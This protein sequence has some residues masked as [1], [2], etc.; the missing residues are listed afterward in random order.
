MIIKK[1]FKYGLITIILLLFLTNTLSAGNFPRLKVFHEKGHPGDGHYIVTEEGTPFFYL[2]DTA[3]ELFHRLNREEAEL[4]LENRRQKNFTVIQ[5]VVLAEFD[6]LNTPNAYGD[7]PLIDNDPT[8]PNITPGSSPDNAV[9]YD[10]WDHVDWIVAK[11]EEKGLFIGMLPTWGDKVY[12]KW[13]IG[14]II[15]NSKN[16]RTYGEWIGNRYKDS[17]NIIWIMGGDRAPE[18]KGADFKPVWRAMAEGIK[19][20]D[21]NHLMT[22]HTWGGT[23]SSTWFH[24]DSWLDFNM[25]QSGHSAKDLNNY[26][27]IFKDYSLKPAK[28][29]MDGELCY[30]DHPVNWDPKNGWFDEYD[31]RKAV[32]RSLFAGAYG[33]TYGCHDIWQFLEQ[34]RK[35]VS[36]ARTPWREAIDLPGSFQMQYVRAL[37]ESRPMLTRIPDQNILTPVPRGET[38]IWATRSVDGSYLFVYISTGKDFSMMISSLSGSWINAW[39]YNPRTGTSEFIKK[40]D[41]RAVNA[42]FNP[43]GEPGRGNDWVLILDDAEKGFAE[44]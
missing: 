27:Q 42:S 38:D 2:G 43:P 31:V 21:T 15:F 6:G 12:G 16:A 44:P 25:M 35:P 19:S 36:Y 37:I 29:C 34:S 9:E 41:K 5:A 23:S 8:R 30:E 4:Y 32:Y 40:I 17:H 22:Y 20:V 11:A 3:W 14:P 39:W 10:Y 1:I 18:D 33:F 26:N 13:G 28:P 24:G 7:T